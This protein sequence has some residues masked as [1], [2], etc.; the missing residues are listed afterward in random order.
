MTPTNKKRLIF[1][2]VI[3]LLIYLGPISLFK[4]NSEI[5]I[6]TERDN[7]GSNSTVITKGN[8]TGFYLNP[9]EKPVIYPNGAKVTSSFI[10]NFGLFLKISQ[11]IVLK[12]MVD[13]IPTH[14][15]FTA[16]ATIWG[17]GNTTVKKNYFNKTLQEVID[18]N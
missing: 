15:H 6:N 2:V 8:Y 9:K 14:T 4:I 12:K 16:H 18:K 13:G 7:N 10:L 5:K 1:S 11:D 3:I 17:L